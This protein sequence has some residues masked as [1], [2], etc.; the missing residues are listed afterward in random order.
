M[1]QGASGIPG[2]DAFQAFWSDF[3]ARMASSGVKPPTPDAAAQMRKAF[4]EAMSQHAEQVLRSEA[5]LQAMKQGMDN[6]LAWQHALNQVMQKGL[7]AMQM[8][9]RTDAEHLAVL[10]R[11]MEDRL[12]DR[13]SEIEQR[14]ERIESGPSRPQARSAENRKS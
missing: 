3:A 6:A 5:F 10:V 8:P 14:L 4:F 12:L 7:A 2:M 9:S 1:N 13:L 11:G